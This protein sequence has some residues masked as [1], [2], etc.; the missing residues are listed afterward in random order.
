MGFIA[1]NK[2]FIW[3]AVGAPGSVHDSRL[4][5]SC[6]LFAEIQQGHPY[7]E[8]TRDPRKRYLSERL[9]LARVVSERAYGM[10]KG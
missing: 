5:K 8:N 10:L 6:D 9:C 7:N 4:L 3:A 1:S 2:R